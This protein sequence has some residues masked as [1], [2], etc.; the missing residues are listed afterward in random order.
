M[1]ASN[2]ALNTGILVTLPKFKIINQRL[3]QMSS[4]GEDGSI[5]SES[6]F[7]S[8]SEK[9]WKQLCPPAFL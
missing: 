7:F 6:N 3:T 5:I 8:L 2:P 1:C 4:H 9:S